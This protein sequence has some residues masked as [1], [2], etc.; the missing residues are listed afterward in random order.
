MTQFYPFAQKDQYGWATVT[1]VRRDLGVFLDIGLNDKDV[2]VS[3]D[4]LP[5]EK[6]QWPKKD[7]RLLVRLETDEKERIWAKMAEENVFEQLAA[8]FPAHLENKNM[9]GTVYRNY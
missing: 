4:D 1:E 3:L 9:S 8:N 5:L 7:D 6:D 2:V